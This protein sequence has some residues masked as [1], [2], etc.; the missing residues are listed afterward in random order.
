MSFNFPKVKYKAAWIQDMLILLVLFFI[1]LFRIYTPLLYELQRP[2]FFAD[3][4]FLKEHLLLPGGFVDYISA[5]CTQVFEYMLPGALII[6]LLIGLVSLFTRKI[7]HDLW[8]V[9]VHTLHWI[10]GLFLLFMYGY[11][12][13]PLSLVIGTAIVL[14]TIWIFFRWAPKSTGLRI[15]LYTL[16]TGFLYWFCGGP[17]LLFAIY[18]AIWELITSKSLMKGV[19]YLLISAAW[20]VIGPTFLFLVMPRQAIINNLPIEAF[21]LPAFARWGF[22]LFF[23]LIGCLSFVILTFR[24]TLEIRFHRVESQIWIG[25][26][27]LLLSVLY[28]WGWIVFDSSL[29]KRLMLFRGGRKNNWEIVLRL[30]KDPSIM[31]PH[32]CVQVNRALCYTGRLLDSA[33]A[34]PQWKSTIGLLPDKKLCFENPEAAS[35]LFFE[36]GLISESLHW[37]NELMEALG[38]TPGILDRLGVIY[39]LKEENETAKMFWRKLKYTLQG[40]KR[41]RYLLEIVE[42]KDL[43]EED[44]KLRAFSS[45]IPNSDFVSLGNPSEREL[46]ILLQQNPKN[47]MAFEYWIAYQLFKGNLGPIWRNINKFRAFGYSRAPRHVQ[48]ALIMYA[49]LSKWTKIDPLKP[50]VDYAI[51]QRFSKF[52]Q[53][54]AQRKLNKSSAQEVLKQEFGDT[55]WYYLTFVRSDK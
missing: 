18:C 3:W 17:F 1:F 42:K 52:Q 54:L 6:T 55:Y 23:P 53:T 41:A 43:L 5:L 19:V 51:V 12:R 32:T 44:K 13:A 40:R 47:R 46:L 48:E 31:N 28:A 22:L 14:I 24:K 8:K 34:Y 7:I 9:Q 35:D 37:S 30:G 25:G 29:S 26:T 39:F 33:F 27:V 49:N 50:Y 45:L 21:Y 11:Y 4:S 15:G 10:P 20:C 36:L 2:V 16:C 38:Q